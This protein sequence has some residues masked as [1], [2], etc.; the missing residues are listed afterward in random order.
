MREVDF[1][2]QKTEGENKYK[3]YLELA[4]SLPQSAL[5]LTVSSEDRSQGIKLTGLL[6]T[7]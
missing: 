2:K 5:R 3:Q 1:A 4:V 7:S 6:V